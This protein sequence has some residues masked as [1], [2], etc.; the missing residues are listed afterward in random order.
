[1]GARM[2]MKWVPGVGVVWESGIQRQIKATHD[3]FNCQ[4]RAWR[5]Y[6]DGT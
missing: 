6:A 5:L 3:D 2:S 1:V 4:T